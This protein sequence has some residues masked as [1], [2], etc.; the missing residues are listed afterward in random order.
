[1]SRVRGFGRHHLGHWDLSSP[2]DT[3]EHQ[4]NNRVKLKA[5]ISAGVKVTQKTVVFGDSHYVL[6]GVKGSAYQWRR[7]GRCLPI[8]P[9]PNS[10]LW[11][12][13]LLAIDC[14]WHL[15]GW[16][17]SPS[18][19]DIPGNEYNEYTDRH[20]KKG[21]LDHPFLLFLSPDKQD[22]VAEPSPPIPVKQR[23][24]LALRMTRTLSAH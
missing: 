17:W 3:T 7:N 11:A 16:A 23:H 12:S 13:L 18:Y 15:I 10:D 1:M 21:Q 19:Q 20:A 9:V 4:T 14:A 6:D 24:R 2:P 5:A 22:L 8:G